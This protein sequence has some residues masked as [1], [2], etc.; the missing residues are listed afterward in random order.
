MNRFQRRHGGGFKRDNLR[1]GLGLVSWFVVV[2]LGAG[3]AWAQLRVS[4]IVSAP[5]TSA[6]PP[7][8]VTGNGESDSPRYSRDGRFL[9]FSS[10]ASNLTTNDANGI[11]RDVF[12]REIATGR[13]ALIS[14]NPSG[15]SGNGDSFAPDISGDGR[16]IAYLSR[17]SDLVDGD[18][19]QVA[20]VFVRD[21]VE[22]TTVRGSVATDGQGADAENFPPR[23][24]SDGRVVVFG[25]RATNL[26]A[27]G[28]D[29]DQ[30]VDVFVRHLGTGVT[31]MVSGEARSGT[32]HDVDDYDVSDDGRWV[33][34]RSIS[35][36]IVASVPVRTPSGVYVRDMDRG[37]TTRLEMNLITV[38][39]NRTAVEGRSM[40]FAPGRPRLAVSTWAV[41][42]VGPT[43][44][45]NVVE[46]FELGDTEARFL[47]GSAGLHGTLLDEP[48]VLS[49]DPTGEVLAFSQTVRS[50]QPAVLRLWRESEGVVTVT[51]AVT[52][53]PIRVQE[54]AAGPGGTRV[55]FTSS[56]VD[57]VSGGTSTNTYQLYLVEP[58]T[59][60]VELVTTNDA[61]MAVG[62]MEFARPGFGPGGRLA[63]QCS[64][65]AL[66]AGDRNRATDVF[67]WE[68]ELRRL[69]VVSARVGPAS[70]VAFGR[71]TFGHGG[72]S[73][74]GRLVLFASTA[75][76]LVLDD[77]KGLPDLFVQ[78][79]AS[80]RTTLV[81]VPGAEGG[82]SRPGFT[83]AVLS[84]SGRFV[85]FTADLLLV[86]ADGTRIWTPQVFVRDL[87]LGV[88]RAV[89]LN[90]DGQ[91]ATMRSVS[92]LQISADGRYV[93]FFTDA[94]TL[95]EG[96]V[97]RGQVVLRDL[98]AGRNW[99]VET[100]DPGPL[101]LTLAGI[102]G[103]TLATRLGSSPPR[104]VLLDPTTGAR[105]EFSV[106]AGSTAGLSYDGRRVVFSERG[107][108]A[109]LLPRIRWRD[110][111][112][113]TFREVALP[114]G[115]ALTNTL[116]AMSRNGR[117]L[118]VSERM[119][120]VQP[121]ARS[122]WAVDLETG[123]SS[124]ID[125]LPDGSLAGSPSSRFPSYSA[126]GRFL[127]FRSAS[128][129]LVVDDPNT[130]GDI[131]IRDLVEKRTTRVARVQESA[132]ARESSG[133]PL[134]S[135]DG[136][137]LVF[138]SRSDGFVEG[139]DN[140]TSDVFAVGWAGSPA[141]DIDADGLEDGWELA[142]FGNL[143]RTG[144][145]DFDGDGVTDRDEYRSGTVP[146][147]DQSRFRLELV[148]GAV[149]ERAL[150]L[151]WQTESGRRYRLQAS[152]AA[153]GTEWAPVGDAVT[154]DGQ[155]AQV[156][157]PMP[158]TGARYFRVNVE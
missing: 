64:S 139:D 95:V 7:T 52:A 99:L 69:S 50:G 97:T 129:D 152:D 44:V 132:D 18:T 25:S 98:V 16:Y 122:T 130:V 17:A 120:L 124:R 107:D 82:P 102:G 137:R 85:A 21:M 140:Q 80:G 32:N 104:A 77:A 110:E 33:A 9:V 24:A 88:T 138:G 145:D 55:A 57:L 54:V 84:S 136:R 156:T 59:G 72:V 8:R 66:V 113:A 108:G 26:D 14:V 100:A 6:F 19:N 78:E 157:I 60:K 106:M 126:D 74:D 128:D 2:W 116:E 111:G 43:I 47:G 46:V 150:G 141:G 51:N 86:R 71:S 65:D 1:R 67:E 154:G 53:Q 35:T 23:L 48:T 22:G 91:P 49:F 73:A 75:D 134:L 42:V 90:P 115:S 31:T 45:T 144:A 117:W 37:A 93:A 149:G 20:D 3:S 105:E 92:Q 103:R 34:F 119:G 133:P 87:A 62:G 5:D 40:A 114:A 70:R 151:S 4:Q 123:T 68:P 94:T 147:D 135:V 12:L 76:D 131:F 155:T 121:A 127:A 109:A 39:G 58:A 83:E 112:E 13:T 28:P 79:L 29:T 38:T 41:A 101:S 11:L 125:V 118:A 27:A 153:T 63:F 81:T 89:A 143:T 146:L 148:M 96:S 56:A 142:W 158:S 30:R 15:A 61:G 10:S 36:N